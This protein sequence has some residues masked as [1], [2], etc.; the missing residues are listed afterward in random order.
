[1]L[2]N[3]IWIQNFSEKVKICQGFIARY[4]FLF[5]IKQ[6]SLLRGFILNDLLYDTKVRYKRMQTGL[7][8]I[9]E[10]VAQRENICKVRGLKSARKLWCRCV[11]TISPHPDVLLFY[12]LIWCFVEG[13]QLVS[14]CSYL[15]K[16]NFLFDIALSLC[17]LIWRQCKI[18]S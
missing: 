17:L 15:L 16:A 13:I 2:T 5:Y 14:P 8:H 18:S 10:N 1:M 11:Y 6:K 3:K 4:I 12:C 9:K 7:W